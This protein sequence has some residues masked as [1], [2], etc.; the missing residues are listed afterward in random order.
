MLSISD[1]A[2]ARM[3]DLLVPR[4]DDAVLRIVRRDGRYRLRVS[5]VLPGD[6]TFAH[7]GRVVLALDEQTKKSLAQRSLGLRHSATGPRL[8][9]TAR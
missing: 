3:T 6:Q 9:L 4:A 8:N 2:A 1:P 7:A 5:R